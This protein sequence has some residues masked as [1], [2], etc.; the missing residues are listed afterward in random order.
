MSLRSLWFVPVFAAAC[1]AA[2]PCRADQAEDIE[3]LYHDGKAEEALAKADAA[4]AA[5]PRAAPLRFLKGVMLIELKRDDEALQVFTAL[6]QDYPELADPYNN[7]AVIYASRGQL[8]NALAALQSALRN[9]PQHRA[10]RENLGDVYLALAQQAWVSAQAESKGDDAE[11]ER[12]LRLVRE[13]LPWSPPAPVLK[14]QTKPPP[15]AM[16]SPFRRSQGLDSP[17]GRRSGP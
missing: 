17:A 3:K 16:T 11:L 7:L 15:P 6:T 12:K 10:A 5:E 1:M 4:V 13:I 8:H 2:L 9:D 14:P